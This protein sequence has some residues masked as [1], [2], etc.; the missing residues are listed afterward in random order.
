VAQTLEGV[1]VA[2]DDV[3][4]A[5]SV[6][7]SGGSGLF[8]GNFC[9]QELW[10]DGDRV[11]TLG[12]HMCSGKCH[13]AFPMAMGDFIMFAPSLFPLLMECCENIFKGSKWLGLGHLL[14]YLHF[15]HVIKI[16]GVFS[17][18]DDGGGD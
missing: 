1:V 2:L 4:P 9:S 7:A 17:S 11:H 5:Y 6:K 13:Q 12:W 18:M 14:A 8:G 10:C 3:T 15:R 16:Q